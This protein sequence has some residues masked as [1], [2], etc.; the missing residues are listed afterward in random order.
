MKKFWIITNGHQIISIMTG[1]FLPGMLHSGYQVE[2][3]LD[4][5]VILNEYGFYDCELVHVGV[6]PSPMHKLDIETPQWVID[7][8][9]VAGYKHSLKQRIDATRTMKSLA[10]INFN[11][12]VFDADENALKNITTWQVQLMAGV[13]LPENFIWRD[14]NNQDHVIDN[15]FSFIN[16][17][18]AEITLRATEL[19]YKAWSKKAEVDAMDFDGLMSYDVDLGW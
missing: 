14:Y 4:Q 12:A 3:D 2:T 10:P 1:E 18:A 5:S 15:G 13:P 19:Y 9:Q 16:G 6:R 7:D 17:L 11:G 8:V